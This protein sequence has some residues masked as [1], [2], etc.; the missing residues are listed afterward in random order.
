[1]ICVS[2]LE[3][4]KNEWLEG[5][6]KSKQTSTTKILGIYNLMIGVTL[7]LI[8]LMM[9]QGK[10]DFS[11]FPD[12]YAEVLPYDSWVLPGVVALIFSAFNVLNALNLL[13]KKVLMSRAGKSILASIISAV[14]L[15]GLLL[16]HTLILKLTFN[17]FVQFYALMVFQL[18]IGYKTFTE[19]K[20]I[21]G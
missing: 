7:L 1:M 15:F 6:V 21:E 2:I 4:V 9:T 16:A 13:G 10:G 5:N 12:A 14:V 19:F 17:A 18:V 8:G 3:K 11:V 20:K